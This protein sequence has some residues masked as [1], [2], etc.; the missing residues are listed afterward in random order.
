MPEYYTGEEVKVRIKHVYWALYTSQRSHPSLFHLIR[1]FG[2]LW[3][4]LQRRSPRLSS[5]GAGL[6]PD[7]NKQFETLFIVENNHSTSGVLIDTAPAMATGW[8]YSI[9][10]SFFSQK[11]YLCS[12]DKIEFNRFSISTFYKIDNFCT[13]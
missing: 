7:M 2:I 13:I 3:Y 5:L 1:R 8:G 10:M 9:F 11:L 12:G 4:N 6:N